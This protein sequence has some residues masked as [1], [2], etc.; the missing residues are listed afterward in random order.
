MSRLSNVVPVVHAG[1]N[2]LAFLDAEVLP[3]LIPSTP[4]PYLASKMSAK[5]FGT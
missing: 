4:P 3:Q 2:V 1:I 5:V